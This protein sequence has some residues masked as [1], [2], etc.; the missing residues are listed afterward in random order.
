MQCDPGAGFP[1]SIVNKNSSLS[2]TWKASQLV[3]LMD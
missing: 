2:H 1:L 3:H